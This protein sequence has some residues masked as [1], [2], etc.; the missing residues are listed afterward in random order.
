MHKKG[1][2]TE[3][4]MVNKELAGRRD[5]EELTGEIL[6]FEPIGALALV[7]AHRGAADSQDQRFVHFFDIVRLFLGHNLLPWNLFFGILCTEPIISLRIT[8]SQERD[9]LAQSWYRAGR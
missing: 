8:S 2:M 6:R 1:T 4:L 9:T 7:S 3:N 5:N